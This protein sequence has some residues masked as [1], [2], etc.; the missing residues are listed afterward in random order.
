L[1]LWFMGSGRFAAKCFLELSASLHFEVVVVPPPKPA[2]RGLKESLS[3]L[4]EVA[5]VGYGPLIRTRDVNREPILLDT[6]RKEWPDV[7]IVVDF[8]QKIKEPILSAPTFGCINI[9]PSL[10]PAYRGAAPIQRAL[11]DGKEETG[12]T[13]F[14]LV[15]AMDAGP[16]LAQR[17]YPISPDATAGQLCEALAREGSHLLLEVLE[18]LSKGSIREEPQDESEAT[19]APKITKDEALIRWGEPSKRVHDL[20]RALNPAPGAFTFAHGKILKIWRASIANGICGKP[21][22]IVEIEGGRPV[23]ACGKGGVVLLEVQQEGKEPRDAAAWWR[24]A[25]LK[26]GDALG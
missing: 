21:G 2:G 14:R 20:V 17:R 19:Y 3:P 12:V 26:K 16:I 25:R 18:G 24:G 9:H 4:E 8:G 11:M 22:E 15:D 6:P 23:V 7:I 10:L 5:K 1:R 13:V